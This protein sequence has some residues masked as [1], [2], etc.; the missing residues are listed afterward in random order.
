VAELAIS[1]ILEVDR[2]RYSVSNTEMDRKTSTASGLQQSAEEASLDA[3][4]APLM[5]PSVDG[6]GMNGNLRKEIMEQPQQTGVSGTQR[7]LQPRRSYRQ[8]FPTGQS[9]HCAAAF[10]C[11]SNAFANVV[12]KVKLGFSSR[13][14]ITSSKNSICDTASFFTRN[15]FS[16]V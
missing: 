10:V 3:I 16:S 14:F 5:F 1:D 13:V 11:V 4:G 2:E 7:L 6:V 8:L 15:T 9:L 12:Q